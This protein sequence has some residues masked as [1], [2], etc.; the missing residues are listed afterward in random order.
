M[1]SFTIAEDTFYAV[2]FLEP[3]DAIVTI[4]LQITAEHPPGQK[5]EVFLIS[6][7]R[8]QL[9]TRRTLHFC[10]ATAFLRR[11]VT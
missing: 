6:L 5:A 10:A 7:L 9:C 2:D 1:Q 8:C 3:M 4:V 11:L